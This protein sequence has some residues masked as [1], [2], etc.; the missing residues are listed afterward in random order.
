ME[1]RQA[2][3]RVSGVV[4][5][6]SWRIQGRGKEEAWGG[7]PS[8]P[9]SAR[10]SL[11]LVLDFYRIRPLSTSPST[12]RCRPPARGRLLHTAASWMKRI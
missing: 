2:P 4:W 1:G 8:S 5:M 6:E 3:S 11:P 10:V 7:V 12:L 9:D